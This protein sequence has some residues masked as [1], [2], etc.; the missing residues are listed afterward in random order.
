M[1]FF[2]SLTSFLSL[3]Q[4]QKSWPSSDHHPGQRADAG[5]PAEVQQTCQEDDEGASVWIRGVVGGVPG[6]CFHSLQLDTLDTVGYFLYTI[7]LTGAACFVWGFWE[8]FFSHLRHQPSLSKSHVFFHYVH[9]SVY[10]SSLVFCIT[11]SFSFPQTASGM[12]KWSWTQ[13]VYFLY[14]Y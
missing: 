9:I 2:R 3:S 12:F 8:R 11:G 4:P 1:L 13:E 5:R 10:D 14:I 6:C 7:V